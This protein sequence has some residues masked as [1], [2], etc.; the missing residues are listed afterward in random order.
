MLAT[1]NGTWD[2]TAV[3]TLALAAVTFAL[4]GATFLMVKLTRR[5]LTQSRDEIALSRKEVEEAHKPVVVPLADS[6][7]M[8]FGAGLT[9]RTN[10]AAKPRLDTADILAV[11]IENVGSGPAVKLEAR[12]DQWLTESG[13][14][15]SLGAGP[16]RSALVAGLGIGVL[17]P[18]EIKL[19]GLGRVSGF[20]ITL[21]YEDVAGSTWATK[22]RYVPDHERYEDVTITAHERTER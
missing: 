18:L 12:I 13:E 3:G 4:A 6:R 7:Q 17:M 16:Q 22:A 11:P 1:F 14:W 19:H 20:W 2:W 9:G 15:S 21:T 5:A 10:W 8:E